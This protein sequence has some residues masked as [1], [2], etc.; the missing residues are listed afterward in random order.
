MADVAQFDARQNPPSG[1]C[2]IRRHMTTI[3]EDITALL[4]AFCVPWNAGDVAGVAAL[5]ADDGRLISPYGHD[6]RGAQA[7][8]EL[9]QAFLGDGPLRGSQTTIRV[10]DIRLLGGDFAVVDCNQIID[11]G[12][13]GRLDL[14]L[15]AVASRGE[16]G[17][18]VADSRPYAFLPLPVSAG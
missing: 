10:E 18:R 14:H 5:F 8:R 16:R 12:E 6:A 4:E 17:W 2:S 3:T 13:L 1:N 11:G 7:I 15:V 9:Y